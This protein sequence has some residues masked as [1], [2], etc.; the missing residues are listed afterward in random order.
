MT[1]YLISHFISFIERH[2]FIAKA[3]LLFIKNFVTIWCL[4]C[5]FNNECLLFWLFQRLNYISQSDIILKDVSI[6]WAAD[7]FSTKNWRLI[8]ILL[9]LSAK[10][11]QMLRGIWTHL[12][13]SKK[14]FSEISFGHL[15]IN[16]IDLSLSL[17]C[18]S[19]WN[20]LH[21]NLWAKLYLR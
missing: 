8:L 16:Y 20:Y 5:Y 19:L 17:F 9:L 3:C 1:I 2:V 14:F 15:L 13:I 4:I 18:R 7:L 11:F 21:Y 10:L 12:A 6:S